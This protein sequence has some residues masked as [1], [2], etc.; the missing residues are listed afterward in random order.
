VERDRN[1]RDMYTAIN[2]YTTR[3]VYRG[4]SNEQHDTTWTLRTAWI[5]ASA[6]F[7]LPGIPFKH[8]QDGFKVSR[9]NTKSESR[10]EEIYCSKDMATFEETITNADLFQNQTVK[11]VPN[12]NLDYLTNID[13]M[14]CENRV[15]VRRT[16]LQRRANNRSF[17]R[18][19]K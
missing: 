19:H 8:L 1:D 4:S 17:G 13:Q 3:T 18:R 12:H 16:L 2:P 14:G 5:L 10:D 11:M 6:H 9:R 7:T 15:N